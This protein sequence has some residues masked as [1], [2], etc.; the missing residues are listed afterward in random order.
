MYYRIVES[1]AERTGVDTES[2]M[3]CV[4][5]HEIGHLLLGPGHVPAGIM[6]AEWDTGDLEAIRKGWLVFSHAQNAGIR[7][8]LR[9]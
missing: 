7:Q 8:E 9:G 5:A 2:V 1:V 3:G 4:M 6:R